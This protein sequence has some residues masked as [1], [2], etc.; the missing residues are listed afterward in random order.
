MRYSLP[1]LVCVAHIMSATN[2]IAD[3]L[4]RDV[5]LDN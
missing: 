4:C 5:T 3:G 2:L 1:A